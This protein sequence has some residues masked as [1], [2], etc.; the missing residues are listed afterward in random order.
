MQT[1]HTPGNHLSPLS[2][3][4]VVLPLV[5]E[6]ND[7]P[8]QLFNYNVSPPGSITTSASTAIDNNYIIMGGHLDQA[9]QD[10]IKKGEYVDFAR[11]LPRD[12][13]VQDDHRMELINK[14]GQT[15]FV[16]VI[17]RDSA[18]VINSFTKWEQAFRVYSNLYLRFNP[19]RATELIQYNHI[20]FTAAS[21][22]L[23]DNVYTYDKE[24]RTHMGNFPHQ[25]WGIIL[26]QAWTMYLKDRLRVH[27]S[28]KVNGSN[29][30]YKSKKEICKRFNKGLCTAGMSCRYDHHC[31]EC[32]KFGHAEH[33]CHKKLAK[34]S[35]SGHGSGSKQGE[36]SKN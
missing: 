34:G 13:V 27:E 14:G 22:Y 17:D 6:N 19:S 11:L 2:Q 4:P 21:A 3:V 30:A 1:Y 7:M 32:G 23:W 29:N 25:N 18:G 36:T 15:Y 9:I 35:N 28:H 5:G 10:K 20:I 31:L 24:F 8:Q 12:R 16:P 26:Q 33:I